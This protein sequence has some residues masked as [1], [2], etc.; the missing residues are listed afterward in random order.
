LNKHEEAKNAWKQGLTCAAD[1]EI[2]LELHSYLKGNNSHKCCISTTID[3]CQGSYPNRP[4]G[5]A[6]K[7]S[8]TEMTA[9]PVKS[10]VVTEDDDK[11]HLQAA[12]KPIPPNFD[13]KAASA[14][15]AAKGLV[16][17]GV[18]Q[19]EIDEKIGIVFHAQL[20]L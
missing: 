5:V 19:Q 14:T 3:M 13:T 10:P 2:Y 1:A 18:G 17:H 12:N 20:T 11:L 6:Q 8:Q 4:S 16:Q 15:V 9:T 7:P